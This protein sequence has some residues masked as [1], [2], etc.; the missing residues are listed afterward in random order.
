MRAKEILALLLCAEALLVSGFTSSPSIFF[1]RQPPR[2]EDQHETFMAKDPT[3]FLYLGRTAKSCG[4]FMT[5]EGG[6]SSTQP[7]ARKGQQRG[8]GT[9]K[10][11]RSG[12]S[13]NAAFSRKNGVK[14]GK[15]AMPKKLANAIQLNKSITL[16]ETPS[17]VLALFV[18]T[19]G[20]RNTGGNGEL[21]SVNF[22]TMLHRIAKQSS[23]FI[24]GQS[25]KQQMQQRKH[26]LVD[27]RFAILICAIAE[28]LA[29]DLAIDLDGEL[30]RIIAQKFFKSRELSNISWGLAKMQ[31]LAPPKHGMGVTRYCPPAATLNTDLTDSNVSGNDQFVSYVDEKGTLPSNLRET[32]QMLRQQ[33]LQVAK[34]KKA[35]DVNNQVRTAYMSTLRDLTGYILDG[36]ASSVLD[37]RDVS[38]FN[39]QE[40]AN[41]L[42]AF[43][44]VKRGDTLL[45]ETLVQRLEARAKSNIGVKTKNAKYQQNNH[46]AA[47]QLLTE[48][49]GMKPQEVSNTIWALA[50]MEIRGPHQVAFVQHAADLME[51][52]SFLEAFKPQELSNTA[53]GV[54]TLISRRENGSLDDLNR[55]DIGGKQADSVDVET[56]AVHRI[57]RRVVSVIK[58]NPDAFKSQEVSNTMWAC[59]TTNFWSTKAIP[60][61]EGISDAILM[62]ETLASVAKS[63]EKRLDRFL[64]QELNNLSWSYARLME[65][66]G[67]RYSSKT[68]DELMQK[69]FDNLTIAKEETTK[70]F[71]SLGQQIIERKE[72]FAPQ[73]VGTTVWAYAT[74][75]YYSSQ[76]EYSLSNVPKSLQIENVDDIYRAASSIVQI[77]GPAAFKPQELSNSLWAFATAGMIPKYLDAFD[78][79]MKPLKRGK[80]NMASSMDRIRDDPI[81]LCFGAAALE[82]SRRPFEFKEQE[83]KDVLWSFS[84]VG[85]RHPDLFRS[86]AKHLVG[87]AGEAGKGNRQG[88]IRGLHTFTPQGIGNL[89]WSYA[90][91]AGAATEMLTGDDANGEKSNSSNGR[92]AVYETSCL[93]LG[94]ALVTHLFSSIAEAS[95]SSGLDI[96]KPQDLSN[97]AWSFATLGLLHTAFFSAVAEKTTERLRN[98]PSPRFRGDSSGSSPSTVPFKPQEL[99]N[100]IW[101]FATLNYRAPEMLDAM[102]GYI[103]SGCRMKN[104]AEPNEEKVA[105][106]FNRQELANIAWSCAVLEQYPEKL[107]PI[108]YT[109]LVGTSGDPEKMRSVMMDTG[110][111]RQ[112]IRTLYYVR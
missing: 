93:D 88:Q 77:L 54:V 61:P 30:T 50:T 12:K 42:W 7:N 106:H 97:V 43:A 111:Q 101:S 3:H 22:S 72:R 66:M 91:Q 86:V 46:Q 112:A 63:A 32:S 107:M 62:A 2:I 60:R 67:A 38:E 13:A 104:G 21:N 4:H 49:H 96:Y 70:L 16:C 44:T 82:L 65:P 23:A 36:I 6:Q 53:W 8:N 27:P 55:D 103:V 89:A 19:G 100:L 92:L 39:T 1:G 26:V 110:L 85:M 95:I 94:E 37:S 78:T 9:G 35:G 51:N 75:G 31:P 90:K 71:R 76:E 74:L 52:D 80:A 25:N 48:T 102:S 5:S 57:L 24:K 45:A 15:S 59:S 73:D 58:E 28:S 47:L 105:A 84:K 98:C 18:K 79:T 14:K 11:I 64:P 69:Y 29:D 33:I 81:T 40:Y 83:V 20:A 34:S 56:M 68:D 87:E 109:G 10:G 17:D 99:A 41:L 108:L